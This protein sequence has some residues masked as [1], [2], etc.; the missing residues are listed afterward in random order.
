M[1][2]SL[3]ILFLAAIA[4]LVIIVVAIIYNNATP[5]PSRIKSLTENERLAIHNGLLV[6]TSEYGQMNKDL[7]KLRSIMMVT[8]PDDAARGICRMLLW[9]SDGYACIP[10]THQDYQPAVTA[11]FAILPLDYDQYMNAKASAIDTIH[12][13]WNNPKYTQSK[14]WNAYDA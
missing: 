3:L 5:N 6:L 11:L 2:T 7:S 4:L 9:F 13:L 12:V 10:S 14:K 8:R 1:S